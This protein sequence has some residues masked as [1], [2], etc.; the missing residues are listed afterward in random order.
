MRISKPKFSQSSCIILSFC[1][2]APH[3]G[4]KSPL[5]ML[6]YESITMVSY[7]TRCSVCFEKYRP[8][9]R[10]TRMFCGHLF[11]TSCIWE[12]LGAANSCPVCRYELPTDCAKFEGAR[13][14]RMSGRKACLKE[15]EL[16]AMSVPRVRQV[17]R[18]L[19]V[20]GHG[21]SDK[22]DLIAQIRSDPDTD[23]VH[24]REDVRYEEAELKSLDLSAKTYLACRLRFV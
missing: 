19:G 15:G 24:D 21:S 1:L 17:M 18:T 5:G 16:R 10:A 11:C 23:L 20:A 12:W 6:S 22:A 14:D 3:P 7:A 13:R 2:L 8:G 9:M 4:F